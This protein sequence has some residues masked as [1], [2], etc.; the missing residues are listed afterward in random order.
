MGIHVTHAN[1]A[2]LCKRCVDL[3]LNAG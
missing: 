1:E 3:R 2:L